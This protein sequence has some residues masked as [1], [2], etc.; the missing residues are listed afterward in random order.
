MSANAAAREMGWRHPR[1]VVSSPT[2][3]AA[4]LRKHMSRDDLARLIAILQEGNS[5]G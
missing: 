4:A 5:H 3:V 1:I 2:A